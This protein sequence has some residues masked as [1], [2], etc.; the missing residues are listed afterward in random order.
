MLP[1]A[2]VVEPVN[3]F[4]PLN[5][6]R[7]GLRMKF[8]GLSYHC[9]YFATAAPD[10]TP[11][12]TGL[13]TVAKVVGTADWMLLA[14]HADFV[15][16]GA[17]VEVFALHALLVE[18]AAWAGVEVFALHALLLE[19][20]IGVAAGAVDD[21]SSVTGSKSLAT[22]VATG[23]LLLETAGADVVG[24]AE[25]VLEATGAAEE[26]A[27]AVPELAPSQTAGPGMV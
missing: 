16:T 25:A 17:T 9:P 14:E 27:G 1:S 18:V 23:A 26:G 4:P 6:V 8:I 5:D 24:M 10:E 20:A 15:E 21:G 13:A 12:A 3:P 22:L 2:Q 7:Q 11:D 19:V